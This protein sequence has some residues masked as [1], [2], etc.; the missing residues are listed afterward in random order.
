MGP[1]RRTGPAPQP[2]RRGFAAAGQPPVLPV[3]R[4]VRS[5]E[6]A[7]SLVTTGGTGRPGRPPPARHRGPPRLRESC[8]N[9]AAAA[10][11][12]AAGR[13]AALL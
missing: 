13:D 8:R 7:L 6:A 4:R 10:D 11:L 3:A 12:S 2:L 9:A 1:S 5:D